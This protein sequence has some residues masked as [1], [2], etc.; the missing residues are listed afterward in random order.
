MTMK[1][2]HKHK[3]N[4]TNGQQGSYW[5]TAGG[6]REQKFAQ[7]GIAPFAPQLFSAPNFRYDEIGFAELT[8]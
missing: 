8:I 7:G 6:Q 4:M 2:E 1:T 3:E 5:K